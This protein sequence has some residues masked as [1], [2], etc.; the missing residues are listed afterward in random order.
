ME[1]TEET[2][3]Y[4]LVAGDSELA[5]ELFERK[6][7]CIACPGFSNCTVG[8]AARCCGYDVDELIAMLE[9]EQIAI[10]ENIW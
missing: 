7:H 8:T 9:D 3:I 4:P 2:R 5:W 10:W 1:I 6:R